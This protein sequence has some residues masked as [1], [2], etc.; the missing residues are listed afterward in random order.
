M[1]EFFMTEK[2]ISVRT[3]PSVGIVNST[4]LIFKKSHKNTAKTSR[5]LQVSFSHCNDFLKTV[6]SCRGRAGALWPR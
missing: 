3:F 1:H 4:Q 6:F 2:H 5:N